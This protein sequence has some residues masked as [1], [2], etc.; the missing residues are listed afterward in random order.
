MSNKAQWLTY[1]FDVNEHGANWN[2]VA[3]VYMFCSL[4]AQNQWVALYIGQTDSFRTRIPRHEVWNPAV[5]AGATH[6]HAMVVPTAAMRDVIEKNLI[7][8]FGP[9][10]NTQLRV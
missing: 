4:N 6:V 5:L 2:D 1:D 3:G 7:Q 9:V 8:A 10:L